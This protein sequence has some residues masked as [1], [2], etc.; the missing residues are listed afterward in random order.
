M[1]RFKRLLV[2]LV[3]L[4]VFSSAAWAKV[5][6]KLAH[7]GPSV[8]DKTE[9]ACQ[10]FK[11]FVEEK[12]KGEIVINTF[13]NNQLGNERELLEGI[14]MG[15]VEMVAT[16]TGAIPTIFP[17]IMVVDIPYLFSSSQVAF[18][19]L[20]GPFGD[21][22]RADYL[23]KT[24]IRMLS[25]GE[26]G[27]R[28][29]TNRVHPIKTPAD[30]KGL[31]IRTMENPAHIAMMKSM[32]AIPVPIPYGELYTA[33]SQGVVD[34]QENP[35]S[36]IETSRFYE[37]QKYMTL[38][39][40]VYSPFT[41]QISDKLFQKLTPDQRKIIEEGAALWSRTHR[42]HNK[43]QMSRGLEVIKKG[44]TEVYSINAEE[45]KKFRKATSQVL[46]LIEKEVGKDR[47]KAALD[48]VAKAEKELAKK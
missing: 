26:N 28:H 41:L 9:V 34:G 14:Q 11:K 16:T 21:K 18:K 10:A 37:V 39:G 23:A 32:G 12:S 13:P 8:G 43:M 4:S 6:I 40:H 3:I 24:G 45:L 48:A 17:E 30:L 47:V 20:D 2:S 7:G 22:L 35:I 29:F 46:P 5:E 42:E 44:G 33:L 25:F 27:Y 19:V 31:K 15:T 1:L 38:D 36:L